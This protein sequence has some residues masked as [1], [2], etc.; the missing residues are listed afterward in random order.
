[1]NIGIELVNC[2][3]Q[4]ISQGFWLQVVGNSM[5]GFCIFYVSHFII[6]CN[7]WSFNQNIRRVFHLLFEKRGCQETVLAIFDHIN[8]GPI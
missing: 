1:L 6:T 7:V 3:K 2:L 8:Q 5:F 4:E